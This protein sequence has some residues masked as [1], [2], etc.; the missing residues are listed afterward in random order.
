MTEAQWLSSTNPHE[1]LA[2]LNEMRPKGFGAVLCKIGLRQSKINSRKLFLFACACC[3]RIWPLLVDERSR[4]AI[5]TA[6]LY[7]D[8]LTGK[9][10]LHQAL[11]SAKAAS[12]DSV[13][14][15]VMVG[16]WQA[17]AQARAAEAVALTLDSADPADEAATWAKE[18]IRAW[19][20]QGPTHEPAPASYLAR[21]SKSTIT[22]EAAWIAE[23][24]AQCDLLYDLFSNPFRPPALDPAWRTPPVVK[25]ADTIFRERAFSKLP[26]LA[27]LLEQAGCKCPEILQ[28]FRNNKEHVRGCWALD[29]LL[30][31]K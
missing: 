22:P 27:K 5:E 26:E 24:I 20:A 14:P 18:A 17:A 29:F 23:G 3:R 15:R 13:R 10:A 12:V 9:N 25:L 21:K 30:G 11:M 7:A 2:F 1:M 19:A 4:Q 6:E 16:E 31:K 28:H 8:G